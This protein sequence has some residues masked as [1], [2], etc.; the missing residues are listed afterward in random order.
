M[1]RAAGRHHRRAQR[2]GGRSRH[3]QRWR[4]ANSSAIYSKATSAF[5]MMASSSASSLFSADPVPISS[6]VL[7]DNALNS[8]NAEEVQKS[9]RAITAG[10]GPGDEIALYRFDQYS[11]QICDFI[12]DPDTLM[13]QL[14]RIQLSGAYVAPAGDPMTGGPDPPGPAPGAPSVNI[15]RTT[16][17][18]REVHQRC[19]LF[20]GRA[21]AHP[22]A[23]P[24]QNRL[25]DFRRCGLQTQHLRFQG[26][27]QS[28]DLF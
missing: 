9:L 16:E 23:R 28:A 18:P 27:R 3:G 7:I 26:Y 22:R 20:R 1:P 14:S 11:Q 2:P 5:S 12:S 10:M 25:S 6:V 19:A 13:A 15:R 21:V 4:R 8:K 17:R 24:S